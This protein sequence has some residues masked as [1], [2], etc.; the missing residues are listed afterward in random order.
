MEG[1]ECRVE[2]AE[3]VSVRHEC[4]PALLEVRLGLHD[5]PARE[6]L[7][8]PRP[9][10]AH[11]PVEVED[12]GRR[13]GALPAGAPRLPLERLA[14]QALQRPVADV[15]GGDVRHGLVDAPQLA[16]R[17]P[18]AAERTEGEPV[19]QPLVAGQGQ[20]RVERGGRDHLGRVGGQAAEP[21]HQRRNPIGPGLHPLL[22]RDLVQGAHAGLEQHVVEPHD[23]IKRRAHQHERLGLE[24]EVDRRP[25]HRSHAPDDAQLVHHAGDRRFERL[26]DGGAQLAAAC[27]ERAAVR[28]DGLGRPPPGLGRGQRAV[29]L[30]LD[31]A[32]PVAEG[33][34]LGHRRA[35]GLLVHRAP[36]Q[37]QVEPLVQGVGQLPAHQVLCVGTGDAPKLRGRIA[38][39][40]RHEDQQ[41]GEGREQGCVGVGADRGHDVVAVPMCCT[42]DTVL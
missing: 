2:L 38:P 15:F 34:E 40:C 35:P 42:G 10:E 3:L 29:E 11:L 20:R 12:A 24:G 39:A 13:L 22:Q 36:R 8:E 5:Q 37:R 17:T 9:R 32:Q 18:P 26:L 27:L 21:Y 41:H 1:E 4:E 7:V 33:E 31:E 30:R 16:A 14:R 6:Q 19:V 28:G 25:A 23:R